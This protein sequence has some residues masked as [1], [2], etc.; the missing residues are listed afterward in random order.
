MALLS[1]EERRVMD[2]MS[3]GDEDQR[4]TGSRWR[5]LLGELKPFIIEIS[6]PTVF[7]FASY[8]VDCYMEPYHR[9]VSEYKKG[10]DISLPVKDTIVDDNLL[11]WLTFVLPVLV[12]IAVCLSRKNYGELSRGLVALVEA[13]AVSTLITTVGKKSCGS[14]RPCFLAYCQWN[15]THCTASPLVSMDARQ[16][17]PSGHASSSGAGLGFLTIFLNRALTSNTSLAHTLTRPIAVLPTI[18]A[19]LIAVSRTID[20]HH[21]PEDIAMGLFI[22]SASAATIFRCHYHLHPTFGV[23]RRDAARE[24]SGSV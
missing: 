10:P 2:N 5:S 1:P 20:N 15:G 19:L 9:A 3:Y 6:T 17:F 7:F 16:S 8:A 24:F 21:R 23:A 12:I 13:L 18:L 11:V 4:D 22:G 14:L